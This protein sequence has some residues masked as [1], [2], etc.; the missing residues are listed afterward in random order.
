MFLNLGGDLDRSQNLIGSKLEQDPCSDFFQEDPTSS[1]CIA[2]V[3]LE[4]CYKVSTT[5]A[6]NASAL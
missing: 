1:I 6:I 4:L 3:Y 2:I 5:H